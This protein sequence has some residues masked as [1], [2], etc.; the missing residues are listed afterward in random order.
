MGSLRNNLAFNIKLRRELKNMS[1]AK[2]AELIGVS[3]GYIGALETSRNWPGDKIAER[4][5]HALGVQ[6]P[7]ELFT[8]PHRDKP[9]FEQLEVRRALENGMRSIARELGMDYGADGESRKG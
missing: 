8:D 5:A 9:T 6:D 3:P 7:G 1:Q 2:L 4:L